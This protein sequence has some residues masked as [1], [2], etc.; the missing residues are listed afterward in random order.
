[1]AAVAKIFVSME[2]QD[3]TLHRS[4]LA[5]LVF[6]VSTSAVGSGFAENSG[7]TPTGRFRIAAKIGEG[8]PPGTIFRGRVPVGIWH[9]G[10]TTAGDLILARILWLDGL[11]PANANTLMRYIYF[12]G[13]NQEH[14]IGRPAS[15][16]CIRLRNADMIT[17][18]DLVAVD[19]R[20]EIG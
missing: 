1:M 7:G 4:G 3:V 14:L 9:P 5:P 8:L 11:D 12:H 2:R 6:P 17:L 10:D 13:T 20:V 19:D 15:L 16:G 18:F